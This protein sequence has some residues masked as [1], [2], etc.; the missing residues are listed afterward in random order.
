M[1][2]RPSQAA[3][4]GRLVLLRAPSL[5]AGPFVLGIGAIA[6][7]TEYEAFRLEPSAAIVVL[8]AMS[9]L[10]ELRRHSVVTSSKRTASRIQ[11]DDE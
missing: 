9:S 3:R 11:G 1:S 8:T 7:P 4:A 10:G 6:A 2:R 5:R